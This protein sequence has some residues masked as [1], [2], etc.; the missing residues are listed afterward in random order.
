MSNDPDETRAE[1][2]SELADPVAVFGK[3]GR[4]LR[5]AEVLVSMS[6]TSMETRRAALDGLHSLRNTLDDARHQ[7]DGVLDAQLPLT[8]ARLHREALQQQSVVDGLADD[9]DGG[10]R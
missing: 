2:L 9:V 7:L 4:E 1:L 5:A 8:H 10:A 6:V 3:L